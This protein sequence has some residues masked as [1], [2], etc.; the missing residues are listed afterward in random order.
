MKTKIAGAA[1]LAG[2]A[3]LAFGFGSQA[4]DASRSV[5]SGVYTQAQADRGKALYDTNC[6][7]CHGGSLGG[8]DMSPPLAGDRFMGAWRG[9]TVGD[10][11]TRTKTTMP[12]NDPGSLGSAAVADITAYMLSVNRVPAGQAE[13]ARDAGA[14]QQIRIDE[15]PAG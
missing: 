13:L 10:L 9:Q 4:Q 5:W 8:S 3:A 7:L 12:A 11:F 6:A 15:K 14:L 1:A 2:V